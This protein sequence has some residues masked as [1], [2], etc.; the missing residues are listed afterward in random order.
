MQ[1]KILLTKGKLLIAV[2]IN[3]KAI[4]ALVCLFSQ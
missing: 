2:K 4:L 3:V 1:F